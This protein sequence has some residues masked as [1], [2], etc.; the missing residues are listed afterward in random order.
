MIAGGGLG[1]H[2]WLAIAAIPLVGVV[3]AML[4][5]R[6]TVLSALRRML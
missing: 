6:L 5:A 3:I 1:W 2:D 4:T